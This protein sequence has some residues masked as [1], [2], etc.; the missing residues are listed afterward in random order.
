MIITLT[1]SLIAAA[2]LLGVV[3]TDAPAQT[4]CASFT[5]SASDQPGSA[6]SNSSGPSSTCTQPIAWN[7]NA[8]S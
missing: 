4:S 8:P 2:V 3:A 7:L 6:G 1:A 5:V